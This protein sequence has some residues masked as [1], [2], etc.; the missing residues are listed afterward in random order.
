MREI[1][2]RVWDNGL[3]KYLDPTQ[4]VMELHNGSLCSEDSK[5]KLFS[6]TE[7]ERYCLEQYTGLKDRTG[8]EIC[9]GDKCNVHHFYEIQSFNGASEGEMEDV[10]TVEWI[11]NLLRF[12]FCRKDIDEYEIFLAPELASD[13]GVEIIGNIHEDLK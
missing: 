2:F 7:N 13:D 3:R 4:F 10:C 1:K 11:Q 5:G 6:L 12:G 8:K 9:E